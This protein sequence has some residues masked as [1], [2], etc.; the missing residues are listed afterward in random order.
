M[1]DAKI[2][3]KLFLIAFPLLIVFTACSEA[4]QGTSNEGQLGSSGSKGKLEEEE[5]TPETKI[6]IGFS[7]DT[8]LEER[9]IKDRDLFKAAIEEQGADVK[10]LAANGDD[11]LQIAQAEALIRDGID[12]LVV[13]PHNADVAAA[14]VNKAHAAGIKVISYDRLIKNADVD[15]YISFDNVE[16]GELKAEAITNIVPKGKYVYIGGAVTDHNAHLLKKGVFNV[17][18]PF[19]D[20]GNITVVYDQ[21]S[22]DWTPAS[23]YE[24]MKAA[25]KAN[26]NEIDAV[27]A[28]NDATAGGVIKALAEQGLSGKIPV[29]GQDADLAAIQRIVQGT[30]VMTVYKSIDFL[31][32]EAAT[33]AVKMAKGEIVDTNSKMNNGK[34]EVP[35]VLL[36][37]IPVNSSNI[38]ETI[39]SDGFHSKEDVYGENK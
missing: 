23:A 22:N 31:S 25:L 4:G 6:K 11:I 34:I 1:L 29:A 27:I 20:Q 14:I 18:Q 8:L 28:A 32:K 9:W 2:L 21:W 3:W 5:G 26:G 10:I 16:V 35:S 33:L 24:N 7:M 15:L 38:N 37:P 39:I 12:L 19:I 30:Q 36:S 17:L 13:V